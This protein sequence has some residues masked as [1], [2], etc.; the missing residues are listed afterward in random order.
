MRVIVFGA[1]GT[2]GGWIA[3]QLAATPGIEQVGVIRKWASAVRLARRGIPLAQADL[4][5]DDVREIVRGADVVVNAAMLSPMHEA[6]LVESLYRLCGEMQVRRFIQLSSAAVYGQCTGEVDESL[7]PSPC[8]AYGAGKARMEEQ[9][10]MAAQD[11]SPQVFI[12]RP[13]VVYGPFSAAWTERYARRIR[14]GGWKTLGE[15]GDGI[16]NLVHGRDLARIVVAA[17]TAE[18]PPGNHVLNVN[19]PDV[20]TWNQYIERLGDALGIADR[21]AMSATTFQVRA[22][23]A[24]ILRTGRKFQWVRRLR[25]Q[26]RG[27]ARSAILSAQQMTD[28]YPDRSELALLRRRVHYSSAQVKRILGVAAMIR[29]QDGIQETGLW[30]KRHGVV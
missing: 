27:L 9:L 10:L 20:I 1:G 12:L 8:D 15:A 3:E 19:G 18:V 23:A 14:A 16:C 30:C 7:A 25:Q 6:V 13:S 29:M 24:S 2:V 4:Q 28:L 22:M 17:A 11:R 5:R 21:Q 26:S